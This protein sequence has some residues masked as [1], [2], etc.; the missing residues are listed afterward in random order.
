LD[1]YLKEFYEEEK[2]IYGVT[3]KGFRRKLYPEAVEER[4]IRAKRVFGVNIDTSETSFLGKL[5]RNYAWD[6]ASLWELAED[7]YNS[8]FVNAA[9]GQDLDSV[10]QYL[11][12]SRRPAQS[13]SGVITVF[14]ADGTLIPKGFKVATSNGRVFETIEEATIQGESVDIKIQSIIKGK[15]SDV[16]SNSINKMV[17]PI[18]GVTRVINKADT[19][20]GLDI[21]TDAEFRERYKKSYSKAGGSTIPALT[22]ALLDI[23]SVVDAEVVE[24][25][26]M[27]VVDG[28]P[29][30]SFECF[31]FGGNEDEIIDAIFRNKSAGIQAYGQVVK[32]V[33]DKKGRTHKIGYTKAISKPIYVNIKLKKDDTYKGDEAYKRAIINYIGG[34][35]K[36]NISYKGLKLGQDVSFAKI[37]G[38]IMCVGGVKDAE[39]TIS[40]DNKTFKTENIEI[41][42]NTIA[43]TDMDKIRISYV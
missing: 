24:N 1:N 11:T 13:S 21:E 31:V 6:E 28:I 39:V 10:G 14:G 12:I 26:T 29:P 16:L 18:M 41:A 7:V 40:D 35:D 19:F 20:G 33:T 5:I 23:D 22:S 36:D 37:L 27:E 9:E 38:V 17:N 30:K 32:E 34:T 3:D 15:D 43:R 2:R 25:T 4:I 42:G 8:A